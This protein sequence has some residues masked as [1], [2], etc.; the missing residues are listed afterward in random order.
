MQLKSEDHEIEMNYCTKTPDFS[1]SVGDQSVTNHSVEAMVAE[2][3]SDMMT[4]EIK[5]YESDFGGAEGDIA[6]IDE[7]EFSYSEN[8]TPSLLYNRWL[9]KHQL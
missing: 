6:P 7:R 5:L 3:N 8:G 4:R 2:M 9:W 1:I